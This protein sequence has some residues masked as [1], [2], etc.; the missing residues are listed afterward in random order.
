MKKSIIIKIIAISLTITGCAALL[1]GCDAP[2]HTTGNRITAGKD[3]QTFNYA[4]VMIDGHEVVSG[5]VTQWRD[6]ENSDVVQVLIGGKYYLTHYSNVILV[7]DPEKG[8]L[9]YD[10]GWFDHN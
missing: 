4:Y 10:S 7:A 5:A 6:Y 9:G 3:V 2:S 8:S 1:F